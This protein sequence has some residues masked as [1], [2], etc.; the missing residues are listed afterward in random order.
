[1][2]SV[3][4]HSRNLVFKANPPSPEKRDVQ[5]IMGGESNIAQ[6]ARNRLDLKL[7]KGQ[8][9]LANV[10]QTAINT[11]PVMRNDFLQMSDTKQS[12]QF[13]IQKI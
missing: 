12:T 2:A 10:R 4:T 6:L 1:M 9:F 11:I 7:A 8:R 5:F 13:L 3:G